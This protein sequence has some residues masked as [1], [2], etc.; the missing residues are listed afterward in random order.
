[1][2]TGLEKTEQ[3][4]ER[5]RVEMANVCVQLHRMEITCVGTALTAVCQ[6]AKNC[7]TPVA[8]HTN[9]HTTDENQLIESP[10]ASDASTPV[11]FINM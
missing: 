10:A 3:A 5:D 7:P 6:C 1:M 4:K 9:K 8:I 2:R 11:P